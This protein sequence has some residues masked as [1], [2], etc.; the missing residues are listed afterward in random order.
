MKVRFFYVLSVLVLMALAC[1]FYGFFIEPKRLMIRKVTIEMP[2]HKGEPLR[3]ALMSDLHIGGRHVPPARVTDIMEKV[4]ALEPDLILIVGDFVSG[5]EPLEAREPAFNAAVRQ[6]I[7]NIDAG[8]IY[9][10]LGNHDVWYDTGV[11]T[12]IL[13]EKMTVLSN[14]AALLGEFC[15]VGLQD[16]DTQSPSSEAFAECPD[17][18][19]I[20]ALMHS[21]DSFYL[22]PSHVSLAVAGHTHGGQINLPI[23]GRAVTS[24][25]VGKPYAY[26]Q[27]QTQ[28]GVPAFVTAGIGTS[29]LSAR[30][31]APPEIVLIR[32]QEVRY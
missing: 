6:G 25:R 20:L 1:L 18:T 17:N 10:V 19:H 32:L 22:V 16:A 29:I 8:D 27:V 7:D 11:V 3:I 5:H 23:L 14:S 4:K 31:R 30:F 21:P 24:T 12:N 2:H 9:A 13:T 26:G 15:I 28:S